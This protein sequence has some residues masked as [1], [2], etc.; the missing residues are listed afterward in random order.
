MHLIRSRVPLRVGDTTFY[1]CKAQRTPCHSI[2]TRHTPHRLHRGVILRCQG[3][4]IFWPPSHPLAKIFCGTQDY[5]FI[6]QKISW[7]SKRRGATTPHGAARPR[8]ESGGASAKK[9]ETRVF[10]P[11]VCSQALPGPRD[12]RGIHYSA[13]AIRWVTF[14]AN[15]GQ[16]GQSGAPL[17][18]AWGSVMSPK[19]THLRYLKI[20][21]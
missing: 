20:H 6:K 4:G 13:P 2:Y 19:N 7:D 3:T 11:I 15:R 14:L 21:P 1:L 10:L 16:W 5:T 12:H 18:L 17:P 8:G 9:I